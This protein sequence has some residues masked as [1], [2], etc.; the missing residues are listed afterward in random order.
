MR[1]FFEDYFSHGWRFFQLQYRDLIEG[2]WNKNARQP[3]WFANWSSSLVLAP[4]AVQWGL[5]ITNLGVWAV[6]GGV[7][8]CH[9]AYCALMMLQDATGSEFWMYLQDVAGRFFWLIL[10]AAL[11]TA[12]I[13][14]LLPLFF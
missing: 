4:V 5:I 2:F 10:H 8:V 1:R 13:K 7:V 12:A 3:F 14:W 11:I 9:F 6:V